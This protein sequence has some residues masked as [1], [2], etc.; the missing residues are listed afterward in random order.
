MRVQI[1][2][3]DLGYCATRDAG[4]LAAA[5]RGTVHAA[6]VLVAGASA[7]AAVAAGVWTVIQNNNKIKNHQHPP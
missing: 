7:H 4:I 5:Q 2:A 3:D 6:S 1:V